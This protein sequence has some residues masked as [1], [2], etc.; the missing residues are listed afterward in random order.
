MSTIN[1]HRSS[2]CM[3]SNSNQIETAIC[4]ILFSGNKEDFEAWLEKFRAKGKQKGFKDHYA[5]T[6]GDIPK[7]SYDID[8]DTN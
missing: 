6:A 7:S 4:V 2:S 8:G 3:S 1:S 5:G